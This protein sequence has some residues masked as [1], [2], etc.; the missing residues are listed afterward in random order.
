MLRIRVVLSMLILGGCSVPSE[1]IR[2]DGSLSIEVTGPRAFR[3]G[4]YRYTV[5][6]LEVA[7]QV[8]S[9]SSAFKTVE[10]YIP[11]EIASRA[12]FSCQEYVVAMMESRREWKF[13]VWTPGHPET[14][15]PTECPYVIVG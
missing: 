13:Y 4:S 14:L 2:S 9:G 11:A 10:L 3:I 12:N 6:T 15:V 1:F 7:M 5:N 8:L